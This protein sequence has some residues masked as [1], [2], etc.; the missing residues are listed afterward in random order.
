MQQLLCRHRDFRARS[1]DETAKRSIR[2]VSAKYPLGVAH[3]HVITSS[4]HRIIGT[5]LQ[6]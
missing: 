3:Q 2:S 6:V 1:L 4:P 5:R